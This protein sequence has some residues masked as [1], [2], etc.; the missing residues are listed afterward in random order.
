MENNILLSRIKELDDEIPHGVKQ[1]RLN[2]AN[3]GYP[4]YY[5]WISG[6]FEPSASGIIKLVKLYGV[7]ADYLL[8][9]S[10]LRN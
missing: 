6:Q 1:A 2:K 5:N 4:S 7:T 9:I 3:I 8:G 10:N